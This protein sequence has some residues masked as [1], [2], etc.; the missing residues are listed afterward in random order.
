M[1]KSCKNKLRERTMSFIVVTSPK[2]KAGMEKKKT[3]NKLSL[4]A[5]I[6]EL[7]LTL[8]AQNFSKLSREI[9]S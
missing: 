1:R 4:L 7:G 3:W 5:R 8:A 6:L 2:K 9:I